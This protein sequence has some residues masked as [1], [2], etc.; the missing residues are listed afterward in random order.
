MNKN[1]QILCIFVSHTPCWLDI[2]LYQTVKMLMFFFL[3]SPLRYSGGALFRPMLPNK[4]CQGKKIG[5]QHVCIP[6]DKG[7][8]VFLTARAEIT[9][10]AKSK[11]PSTEGILCIT[12]FYKLPQKSQI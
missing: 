5:E 7:V 2:S 4:G 6:P 8:Y 11:L 3:M 12:R 9:N 10:Q 1:P